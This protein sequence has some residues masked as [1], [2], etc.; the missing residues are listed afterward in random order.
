MSHRVTLKKV[1]LTTEVSVDSPLHVDNFVPKG[2][3]SRWAKKMKERQEL[4]IGCASLWKRLTRGRL[5]HEMPAFFETDT[6]IM[7]ATANDRLA[8]G[9]VE[10]FFKVTKLGFKISEDLKAPSSIIARKLEPALEQA[11][12]DIFK[13]PTLYFV[14]GYDPGEKPTEGLVSMV[15]VDASTADDVIFR[16]GQE[17]KVDLI[18][19]INWLKDHPETEFYFR[20]MGM[21]DGRDTSSWPIKNICSWPSWVRTSL[22]G[23]SADIDSSLP[24]FIVHGVDK[25]RTRI[26]GSIGYTPRQN[27]YEWMRDADC[28]YY[29]FNLVYNKEETRRFLIEDICKLEMNSKNVSDLKHVV[30]AICNGSRFTRGLYNSGGGRCAAVSMIR[31]LLRNVEGEDLDHAVYEFEKLY[32]NF[33]FARHRTMAAYGFLYRKGISAKEKKKMLFREY[34]KWERVQRMKMW[35]AAGRRGLHLHDGIDGLIG[36]DK[37]KMRNNLE[38]TAPGLLFTID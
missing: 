25:Q 22:F 5:A 14:A 2:K 10:K 27:N 15:T 21:G 16:L 26:Y 11:I 8:R 6:Y 38:T 33:Q 1:P 9:I 23:E 18:P 35:E 28:T 3:G 30:S 36:V 19:Q 17:G 7:A 12:K 29:P 13:V 4:V 24:Q 20:P 31:N 32:R 37:D 34:F